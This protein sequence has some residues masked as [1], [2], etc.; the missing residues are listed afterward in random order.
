MR[1]SYLGDEGARRGGVHD[2]RV[3]GLVHKDGL[4]VI[5]VLD[6]DPHPAKGPTTPAVGH[7]DQQL[8]NWPVRFTIQRDACGRKG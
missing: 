2:N 5:D 4:A 1:R 7:T 3:V 6:V 8:Q